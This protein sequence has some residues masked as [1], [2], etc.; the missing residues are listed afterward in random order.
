MTTQLQIS[1]AVMFDYGF[2]SASYRLRIALNLKGVEPGGVKI[3]NLRD[4]DQF[5]A[6]YIGKTSAPLVPALDFG[7][8]THGQSLAIIEWLDRTYPEPKLIPDDARDALVVR[9]MA[10]VIACDIH[11]INNLRVLKYLT[12]ELDVSDEAKSRWYS[13]WVRS[14]FYTLEELTSKHTD[15]GD[16]C[17]GD[18]PT[19]ADICLVPQMANAKRF[20]VPVDDFSRLNSITQACSQLTAFNSAAP[21]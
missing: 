16:F 2:S 21:N 9:E 17:F 4:G 3:L 10:Y 20:N 12:D 18:A 15:K 5:D 1:D 14:G 7:R 6:G 19:L 13:K 8:E 11:P